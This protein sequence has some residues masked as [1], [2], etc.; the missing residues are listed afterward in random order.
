MRGLP[1]ADCQ[2]PIG[3]GVRRSENRQSAIGNRQLAV[4]NKMNLLRDISYTLRGLARRPAPTAIALD[5]VVT[6]AVAQR[7]HE[8]GIRMALGA[9]SVDVLRLVV[10][11]GMSMAVSGVVLGLVGAFA[12]TRLVGSL[13]FGVTSTDLP[14]FAVVTLGLLL[15][16]LVA[17]YLPALRAT[18][19]EPLEALRYE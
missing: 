16:A 12:L 4:G 13:L 17:C 6:Y 2:L 11:E 9:R 14:T 19:V 7:T 15:I 1:R 8:I 10:R 3:R 5:G 18:K